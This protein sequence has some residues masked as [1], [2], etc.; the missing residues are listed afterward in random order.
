VVCFFDSVVAGFGALSAAV[1]LSLGPITA[2]VA[3][4][5]AVAYVVVNG[6]VHKRRFVDVANYLLIYIMNSTVFFRGAIEYIILS[7]KI[8]V[9]LK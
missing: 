6:G 9:L 5:A 2:I 8:C 4:L 7:F 1:G 3:G